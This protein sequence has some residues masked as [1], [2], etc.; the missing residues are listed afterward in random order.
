MDTMPNVT[1]YNLV[2]EGVHKNWDPIGVAAYADEMGEYDSYVPTLCKLIENGANREQIFEYLW[3]V[4]T[5]SM[6]LEGDKAE[7]EI[8]ADWLRNSKL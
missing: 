1:L 3:I 8:F 7:T 5:N 4:E 2:R 6:G